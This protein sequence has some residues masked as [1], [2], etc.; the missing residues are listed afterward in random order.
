MSKMNF[1]NTFGAISDA[2][3]IDLQRSDLWKV[4]IVLPQVL[5]ANWNDNV[6][7]LLEKFPFPTREREMIEVKY[8]QQTN[9]IIGKDTPTNAIEIPVRYA[10]GVK[11]VE[12]LEKWNWLVANP[13][14]GGIGLTSQC[15]A[16][17][18]MRWVVP[19]MQ[20]QVNA[21]SNNVAAGENTMDDGLVYNL[22]GCIIKGLKYS[23]ADM[24]QSGYVNIMFN[25]Q[26]DRYYPA[27]KSRNGALDDT[28][29]NPV[30]A[31]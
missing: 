31:R 25:L 9:F 29:V 17:G 19:N 15:K 22:E 28:I 7:F 11:V 13:I 14:T 27:G 8:M 26:I 1:N 4:D 3:A 2:N 6:Q 10:F 20:N 23:D 21:L 16:K 12:A 24:T 5:N 30:V 18:S